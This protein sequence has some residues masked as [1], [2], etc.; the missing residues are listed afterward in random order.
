MYSFFYKQSFYSLKKQNCYKTVLQA[1]IQFLEIQN[2]SVDFSQNRFYSKLI[3][4]NS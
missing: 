4:E 3:L 2:Q 1:P